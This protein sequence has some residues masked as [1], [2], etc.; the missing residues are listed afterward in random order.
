MP[1]LP[2][3]HAHD[4]KPRTKRILV[5]AVRKFPDHAR[6]P[7]LCKYI[8]S[9]LTP[10][11]CAAVQRGTLRA[12]LALSDSEEL[13]RSVL[14]KNDARQFEQELKKSDEWLGLVTAI[15]DAAGKPKPPSRN[16]RAHPATPKGFD[17]LCDKKMDLASKYFDSAGLSQRQY[18]CLS[19]KFEYEVPVAEIARRL[20]LNRK[21]V[22][23]H[24][25][26][27]KKRLNHDEEW[28]LRAKRR[29]VHPASQDESDL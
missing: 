15:A 24:I 28:R 16:E 13:L 27:G 10:H 19:M 14:I 11:F 3:D 26:A 8:F 20:D 7:E 18:D 4:L 1:D 23:E 17:G 6:I 25:D 21:T 9:E 2:L 12:D 5:E 22:Q 29:A